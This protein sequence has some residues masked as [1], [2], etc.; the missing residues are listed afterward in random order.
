MAKSLAV[1]LKLAKTVRFVDRQGSELY[2]SRTS[3]LSP[4]KALQDLRRQTL[5]D[6]ERQPITQQWAVLVN[7]LDREGV[8]TRV[9]EGVRSEQA[10][11]ASLQEQGR[12]GRHP[13][14]GS[15]KA[16]PLT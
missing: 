4:V 8:P 6:S 9:R 5:Q 1:V 10:R 15:K 16:G 2:S 12:T 3:A 7:R 11:F 14:V 13:C